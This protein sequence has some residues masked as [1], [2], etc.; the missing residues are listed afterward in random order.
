MQRLYKFFW[1]SSILLF[2][3]VL[4]LVYSFLMERTS[5]ELQQWGIESESQLRQW[6]F[7]GSLLVFLLVNIVL[8][9]LHKTIL[10]AN[11]HQPDLTKW[12]INKEIALWLLGLTASINIFLVTA[13]GFIGIMNN[14]EDL[15]LND[16]T[17]MIYVGPAIMILMFVVLSMRLHKLKN[18]A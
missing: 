8:F 17:V 9:V 11:K 15:R 12:R 7:W 5:P 18:L 3:A 10:R 16:Y 14:A 1:G 4:L 2:L 13:M 6:F